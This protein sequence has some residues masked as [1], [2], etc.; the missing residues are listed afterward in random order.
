MN[1]E[2][3]V[4]ETNEETIMN[5]VEPQ[6]NEPVV[7]NPEPQMTE[8]V[9]NNVEPQISEPIIETEPV[10]VEQPKKKD[11]GLIVFL[12]IVILLLLGILGYIAY[13]KFIAPKTDNKESKEEKKEDTIKIDEDKDY[14]YDAEYDAGS[15][16]EEYTV[17]IYTYYLK[18][19]VVP[20]INIDSE[21]ARKTN[22]SIKEIYNELLS[23]YNDGANG[24]MGYVKY[25]EYEYFVND[26]VLSIVYKT[27]TGATDIVYPYYHTYNFSLKTGEKISAH[28]GYQLS[29]M[30]SETIKTKA[31]EQIEN[32]MKSSNYAFPETGEWSYAAT[33][34]RSMNAYNDAA[35]TGSIEFYFDGRNKLN[36]QVVV[37]M[38]QN[39]ENNRQVI[40]IE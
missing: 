11:R 33:L 25:S 12:I 24:G 36:L 7:T 28:T 35:S 19:I 37:S 15:A 40:T 20:Y 1:E 34:E 18:D 17:G 10:R 31:Q 22:E 26:D 6:I 39:P 21:A 14:V 23:A 2:N 3:K 29:K 4:V 9:T 16:P 32:I 38:G 13:D 5:N 30:D 27:G 8:P